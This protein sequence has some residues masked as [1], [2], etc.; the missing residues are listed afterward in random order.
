MPGF[1]Y[2]KPAAAIQKDIFLN[3]KEGSGTNGYSALSAPGI[4]KKY[5]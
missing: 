5:V 3:Q 1:I 2:A 4:Y